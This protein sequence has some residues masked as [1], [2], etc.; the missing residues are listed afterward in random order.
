MPLH[1][2]NTDALALH[3]VFGRSP[4]LS[5]QRWVYY[6]AGDACITKRVSR[7]ML[8]VA[9]LIPSSRHRS[10]E[11][12]SSCALL[13]PHNAVLE[14]SNLQRETT[15]GH[16]SNLI[17]KRVTGAMREYQATSATFGK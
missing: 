5:H 14:M 4:H 8:C 13:T 2:G 9:L 15:V 17:G 7:Q 10:A 16:F 3:G 11:R 1:K 12:V 6:P